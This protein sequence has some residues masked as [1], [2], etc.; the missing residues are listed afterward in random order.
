MHSFRPFFIDKKIQV[1]KIRNQIFEFI[2]GKFFIMIA[3]L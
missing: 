2:M 1:S 3:S